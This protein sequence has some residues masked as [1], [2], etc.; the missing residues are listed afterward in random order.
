MRT[1]LQH[2]ELVVDSAFLHIADLAQGF[3]R[4]MLILFLR[5]E[6]ACKV[7]DMLPQVMEPFHITSSAAET[8]T[9]L[10]LADRVVI[11]KEWYS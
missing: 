3:G 10:L 6:G 9:L 11:G 1:T 4:L 7:G 2:Y 8:L 5:T